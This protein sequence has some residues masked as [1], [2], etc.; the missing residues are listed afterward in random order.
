MIKK[1]K[2]RWNISSNFQLIIIL[3]VFSITGSTSAMIGR[4]ILNF[5]GLTITTFGN[6]WYFRLVYF[7]CYVLILFPTYQIILMAFAS[8]FGQFPFF[9]AFE[10]KMLVRLGIFRLF[11]KLRITS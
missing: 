2:A 1:L 4:P 3:V 9:W 5:L 11:K 7:L 8:L 6:Q 10:K